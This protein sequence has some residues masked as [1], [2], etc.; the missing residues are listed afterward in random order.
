MS[1]LN[2]AACPKCGHADI[3]VECTTFV[4]HRAGEPWL[5]DSDDYE[6]AEPILGGSAVCAACS[7]EFTI[8]EG[9]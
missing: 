2:I 7:H 4:T 1:G 6:Q 5:C 8:T 3:H 9:E